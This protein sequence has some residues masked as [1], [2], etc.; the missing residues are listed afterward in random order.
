VSNLGFRDDA[1]QTL[2]AGDLANVATH[3]IAFPLRHPPVVAENPQIE[4]HFARQLAEHTGRGVEVFRRIV[5][6]HRLRRL[7]KRTLRAGSDR[8]TA[9]TARRP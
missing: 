3:P 9:L 6:S 1:T 2:L 5:P 4:R 8:A 7:V